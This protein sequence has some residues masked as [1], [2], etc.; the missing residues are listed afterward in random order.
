ML[1]TKPLCSYNSRLYV[2]IMICPIVFNAVLA[3][4]IGNIRIARLYNIRRKYG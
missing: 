3:K 1:R 2:E 4:T